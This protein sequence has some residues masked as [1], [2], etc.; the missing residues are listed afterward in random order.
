MLLHLIGLSELQFVHRAGWS[1]LGGLGA[2]FLG[3]YLLPLC[4]LIDPELVVFVE[5]WISMNVR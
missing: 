5:S 3:G 2:C 4:M 1:V